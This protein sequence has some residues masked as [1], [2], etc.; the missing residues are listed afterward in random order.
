MLYLVKW[1]EYAKIC[2]N[3][4]IHITFWGHET[5]FYLFQCY[6]RFYK[7]MKMYRYF[8]Y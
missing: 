5:N 7:N 2:S 8:Y 3:K 6:F 1:V 4:L